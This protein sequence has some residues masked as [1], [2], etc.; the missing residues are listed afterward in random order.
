MR[1]LLDLCWGWQRVGVRGRRA[2]GQAAAA[3]ALAQLESGLTLGYEGSRPIVLG[4]HALAISISH[5]RE[6]AVAVVGHVARLGIDLCEYDRGAQIRAIAP[7]F[8]TAAECE[9][10]AV[11]RD[12]PALWAA[13]WAAKEAGLKALGRG[14]EALFD[15]PGLHTP[16]LPAIEIRSL[17]PPAYIAATA[18]ALHVELRDQLA[19]AVA[20]AS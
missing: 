13:L 4:G 5:S 16:R 14:L 9:L 7:R 17:A 11:D 15:V 10:I 2:A 8:L 3:D 1:G 18:L 19:L 6:L 20:Y 12:A